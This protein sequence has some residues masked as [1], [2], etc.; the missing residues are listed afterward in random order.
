MTQPPRTTRSGG[1]LVVDALKVNGVDAVFHVPGESFTPILD[2]LYDE[3][4]GIRLITCRH[5]AAA[6]NMAEAYGKLTGRPGICIVTRSPGASH[7]S[8]GVNVAFQ[9][10]TPMILLVGQAE[11]AVL[12]REAFQEI[13]VTSMFGW[14][15]KWAVQADTADAL[16]EILGRAFSVA[17]SGRPGPVVIALPADVL[18][19][20]TTGV[21]GGPSE[22]LQ[23]APAA[24]DLERLR[25]LLSA[26]QRPLMIVGGGGWTQAACEGIV[27]FAEAN[28][29][30]TCVS[31]R[32]QDR[33]DNTHPNYAGDLAYAPDPALAARV[34]ASDL[35]LAVGTRLG[36]VATRA[37]TTIEAP[38]PRQTL[39]HVYPD[40]DELGRILTPALAINSS[41]P[42]FVAA[43]NAFDAVDH[44]GW[45]GWL[46][47]ARADYAA[48]L[49]PAPCPGDLDMNEVVRIVRDRLPADAIITNDAGN[50]AQWVQR[51]YPFRRFRTQIG[52]CN[53]A[54]GYG[55]PAG[56]AAKVVEPDRP[57][58]TFVGD[59]GFLMTGS[60]IATA[61]QFGLAPVILVVNNGMF[62]TIRNHQERDFPGRVSGTDLRNP[63]FAK[64]AESFGAFAATVRRTADFAPAFEKA[65]ACGRVAVLDLHLD[66]DAISPRTTLSALRAR[67]KAS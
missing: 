43:L 17:N 39:I 2:A 40:P 23:P 50:F 51:Y 62:G 30:P 3:R 47:E 53:G 15:A 55:V 20:Q 42:N 27:R 45:S 14:T 49:E 1:R 16:P 48:T 19:A 10:S 60:E 64:Y 13:D 31:F 9:D 66:P 11:S 5:E 52:P 37:Y 29:L 38:Q 44:S 56:N 65:L 67:A 7:A 18:T 22:V 41:M 28:G 4:N 36:D 32:R 46:A 59:G 6:A 34:A 61:M 54:M 35:I 58:V 8:V 26:A 25:E 63:D 33:F 21:M 57:V 24:S 12:G